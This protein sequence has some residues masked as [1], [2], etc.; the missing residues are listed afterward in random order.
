[1][2]LLKRITFFA[3]PSVTLLVAL[4]TLFCL[5]AKLHHGKIQLLPTRIL[6]NPWQQTHIPM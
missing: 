5:R 4:Q 6:P 1:M 2:G 3:V